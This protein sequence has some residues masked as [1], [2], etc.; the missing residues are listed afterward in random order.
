VGLVIRFFAVSCVA[1]AV[2]SSLVGRGSAFHLKTVLC[3]HCS[4]RVVLKPR[5]VS[6]V[7]SGEPEVVM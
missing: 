1:G 5:M 6:C 2:R 3:S 7:D 4:G